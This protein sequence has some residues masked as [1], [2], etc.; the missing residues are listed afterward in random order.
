MEREYTIT[1]KAPL[2]KYNFFSVLKSAVPENIAEQYMK[3]VEHRLKNG[4]S[5]ASIELT[6]EIKV[7][8][9]ETTN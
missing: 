6:M 5:I 1:I 3:E 4:G 9:H 7:K 8:E 2:F